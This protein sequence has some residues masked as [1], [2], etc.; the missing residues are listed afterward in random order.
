M[1]DTVF[2][3]NGTKN[4]LVVSVGTVLTMQ[5]RSGDNLIV[6]LQYS[7]AQDMLIDGMKLMGM[8]ID[9]LKI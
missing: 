4:P 1:S 6:S 3:W 8:P 7:P 5:L 9:P 2:E